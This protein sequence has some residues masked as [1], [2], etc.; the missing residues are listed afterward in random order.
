MPRRVSAHV[1][2]VLVGAAALTACSSEPETP[3]ARDTYMTLEDCTADWGRPE[4]CEKQ[5]ITTGAGSS[6]FFHGPTYF[7]PYRDVAQTEA[8]DEARRA[9]FS[10]AR[11]GPSNRSIGRTS[12]APASMGTTAR[13][14]FGASARGFSSGG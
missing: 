1:T 11:E 13:G 14:G 2:L 10:A 9:G 7:A 3:R 8:R 5:Q 4:Y 6:T 12:V